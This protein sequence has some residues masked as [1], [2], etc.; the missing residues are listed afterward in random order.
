M[1]G[2]HLVAVA[3]FDIVKYTPDERPLLK[4]EFMVAFKADSLQVSLLIVFIVKFII[5]DG[6]SLEISALIPD[7][8]C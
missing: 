2:D 1:L 4:Y 8:T 3:I 7:S 5:C 6:H